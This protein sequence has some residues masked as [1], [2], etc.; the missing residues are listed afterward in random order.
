MEGH[1]ETIRGCKRCLEDLPSLQDQPAPKGFKAVIRASTPE[2]I[3][4]RPDIRA[5]GSVVHLAKNLIE[6]ADG[7][8]V[9]IVLNLANRA[10]ESYTIGFPRPG[11]WRVRFN[12]DWSGYSPDFTGHPGYHTAAATGRHDGLDFH[13]PIGIGPYTALILT[14]G[15]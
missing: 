15:S 4:Q 10:Y 9:V 2:Q 3:G 12:S 8:D 1:I 11:D 5:I 7:D 6:L 13:G 14:Q